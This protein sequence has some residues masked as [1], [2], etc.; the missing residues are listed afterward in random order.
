[1]EMTIGTN[2]K[3][4][5][6]AKSITQ[7]Q[8]SVA[9]NVTCAAVSKWERGETY[10]DITLLQPLAYYFGVSLD[11]LMGYNHEK[12]QAEIDE[13]ITLYKRNWNNAKG[14]EIIT[15]AYRDYPND[16]R[17]MHCYMWNIAGDAAD[18]DPVTL[19]EH[20]DEFLAIC[21]KIIG[22]CTIETLRLNAWNMRAKILHAEGKTDEA[23]EIYETKFINWYLTSGQKSEQLFAKDTEEYYYWVSKNMYE[24]VAFAGDKLG[25]VIFFDRSLSMKEKAEKAI[26]YGQL[27]IDA[28][29]ETGDIFFAGLAEAFL[30][31]LRNDMTFRGGA[32]EDIIALLDMNLYAAQRIADAVQTDNAVHQ[33]YFPDRV[34]VTATDF[35]G[36]LVD[37]LL[38]P[39]GGRHK[40]LLDNPSYKAVLE[41]YR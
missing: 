19:L 27:M 28:L 14:R 32:D 23:L 22:E 20:K 3:R 34:S 10:P 24:L 38:N 33:A 35:L 30:N 1:M 5:R 11:E 13:V 31:R 40:E 9:M 21:D 37:S 41:K 8:L 36:W 25:R 7:E 4:L 6:T 17:I 39:G 29:N 18:N 2:I 16:H 12:V 26:R 15:K